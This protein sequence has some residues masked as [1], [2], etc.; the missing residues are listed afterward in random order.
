MLVYTVTNPQKTITQ[1]YYQQLEISRMRAIPRASANSH[2]TKTPLDVVKHLTS[3]KSGVQ[4][5]AQLARHKLNCTKSL[6]IALHLCGIVRFILVGVAEASQIF[7]RDAYVLP[8][9]FSYE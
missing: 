5:V 9:L 3:K 1:P 7:L 2:D 8:K 6:S 4:Q